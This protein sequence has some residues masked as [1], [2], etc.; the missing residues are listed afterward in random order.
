[1]SDAAGGEDSATLGSVVTEAVAEERR[2]RQEQIQK[3]VIQLLNGKV[4]E[5]VL[6]TS[7]TEVLTYFRLECHRS[8]KM[9]QVHCRIV[10]VCHW[11]IELHAAMWLLSFAAQAARRCSC[12]FSS[13]QVI[14]RIILP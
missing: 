2:L 12:V 3:R 6:T 4:E 9:F 11:V 7:E 14:A 1:M 8:C 13:F 5:A 10:G